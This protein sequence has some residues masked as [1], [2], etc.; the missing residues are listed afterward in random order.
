MATEWIVVAV[1]GFVGV[2]AAVGFYLGQRDPVTRAYKPLMGAPL[3]RIFWRSPFG[4]GPSQ[5]ASDG[6]PRSK[7]DEGRDKNADGGGPQASKP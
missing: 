7:H 1:I 6:S 4:G 5:D 2:V 3:G